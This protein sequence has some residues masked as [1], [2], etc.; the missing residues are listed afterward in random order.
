MAS[1]SLSKTTI[2]KLHSSTLPSY[3]QSIED[4]HVRQRLSYRYERILQETKTN[5]IFLLIQSGE[6]KLRSC[7]Q[8]FDDAMANI[9]K[10]HRQTSVEQRLNQ[11]MIEFIDHRLKNITERFQMIHQY[12][13]QYFFWQAPT[14]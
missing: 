8:A 12:R 6:S 2:G 4:R 14:I 5:M 9:W 1:N 3:I 10:Q 13:L 7:Q 11:T